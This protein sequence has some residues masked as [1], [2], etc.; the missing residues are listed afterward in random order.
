MYRHV[1]ATALFALAACGG[2][3]DSGGITNPPPG[4][5]KPDPW[6]TVRV[7]NQMDTTTAP[8][9]ANWRVYALL[10][11]QDANKNGWAFQAS[12]SMDE[13]RANRGSFCMYAGADSVGQRLYEGLALADTTT[14][15]A[16]PD[17]IADSAAARWFRNDHVLPQGWMALTTTPSDAWQSQ[18]Y[19]A[20]HGLVPTDPIRLGFDWAGRGTVAFY[21]RTDT[22][23]QCDHAL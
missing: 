4:Q 6:I 21:E 18:Q 15:S 10:T 13:V 17:A 19:I 5:K 22:E 14:E 7:R 2:S 23:S 20:G 3:S 8:G 1:L 9:R 12:L 16:R 11:G